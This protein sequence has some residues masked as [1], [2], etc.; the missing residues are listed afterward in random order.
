[1]ERVTGIGGVFFRARDQKALV[2]WY[3]QHLGVPVDDEGYVIFT[4]LARHALG[5]V[6]REH[7]ATGRRTSSS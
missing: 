4:V 7:R 6:R 2:A 5:A 1:M 3:A